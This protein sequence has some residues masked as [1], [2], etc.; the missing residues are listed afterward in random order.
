MIDIEKTEL[1]LSG[2]IQALVGSELTKEHADIVWE[3]IDMML[4]KLNLD[5]IENL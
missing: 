3:H 2:Y 4:H 5:Q 1:Y